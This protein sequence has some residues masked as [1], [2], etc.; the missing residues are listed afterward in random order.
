MYACIKSAYILFAL[1]LDLDCVRSR[2]GYDPDVA[3]VRTA[4]VSVIEISFAD[5]CPRMAN[6]IT[7]IKEGWRTR[8]AHL[9]SLLSPSPFGSSPTSTAS[10]TSGGQ[11]GIDI[12]GDHGGDEYGRAREK[13]LLDPRRNYRAHRCLGVSSAKLEERQA[14]QVRVQ[15]NN[16][17]PKGPVWYHEKSKQNRVEEQT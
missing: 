5:I 8:S 9:L 16:K 11:T 7:R 13:D 4:R 10:T 2:S 15:R 14:E 17:R 6:R 1:A 12:S 3:R